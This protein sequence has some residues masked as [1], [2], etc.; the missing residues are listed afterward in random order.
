MKKNTTLK[1][2]YLKYFDSLANHEIAF[3]SCA[4]FSKNE[5]AK[6]RQNSALKR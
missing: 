1:K 2:N 6:S 3:I 5:I 4:F